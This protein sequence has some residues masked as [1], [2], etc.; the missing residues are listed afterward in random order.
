MQKISSQPRR[1]PGGGGTVALGCAAGTVNLGTSVSLAQLEKRGML[2]KWHLGK[3]FN[4]QRKMKYSGLCH[5]K[6]ENV[7]TPPTSSQLPVENCAHRNQLPN[8]LSS[9][10]GAY[11]SSSSELGTLPPSACS[12]VP[13]LP[14]PAPTAPAHGSN[15]GLFQLWGA[16]QQQTLLII[17]DFA[18]P[19][20]PQEV[21]K[22]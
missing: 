19:S 12:E 22:R 15:S 2:W 11:P 14:A 18:S 10:V 21:K 4:P 8:I 3:A 6:F 20:S 17:K 13:A 16:L 1:P 9:L 7:K 5:P